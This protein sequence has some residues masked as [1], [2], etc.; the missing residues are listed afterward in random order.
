MLLILLDPILLGNIYTL[1]LPF[2]TRNGQSFCSE[3]AQWIEQE[4]NTA[5]FA[6]TTVAAMTAFATAQVFGTPT[7]ERQWSLVR[8]LKLMKGICSAWLGKRPH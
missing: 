8:K 3:C 2:A 1:I 4:N 6:V 5:I 7:A